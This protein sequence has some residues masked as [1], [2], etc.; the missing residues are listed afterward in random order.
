ML[1]LLDARQYSD[2]SRLIS[3]LILHRPRRSRGR[4]L[5]IRRRSAPSIISSCV[6]RRSLVPISRCRRSSNKIIIGTPSEDFCRSDFLRGAC[7]GNSVLIRDRS[8]RA[9]SRAATAGVAGIPASI[10]SATLLSRREKGCSPRVARRAAD[11][12]RLSAGPS[13][14]CLGS[15]SASPERRRT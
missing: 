13:R 12:R 9:G 14:D 11:E 6:G 5:G 7:A 1:F 15:P 8:S 2:Y 10:G 4:D 3:R